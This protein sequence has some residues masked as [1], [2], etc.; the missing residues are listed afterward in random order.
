MQ[1]RKH[2]QE[3]KHMTRKRKQLV[4]TY[5]DMTQNKTHDAKQRHMVD[6]KT[7][8]LS[9]ALLCRRKVNHLNSDMNLALRAGVLNWP[10]TTRLFIHYFA[11]CTHLLA[12][13]GEVRDNGS[14]CLHQPVKKF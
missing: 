9:I 11:V 8:L 12:M 3:E 2:I 4:Q 1:K 5:E 14:Y 13:A 7:L 10:A 6:E